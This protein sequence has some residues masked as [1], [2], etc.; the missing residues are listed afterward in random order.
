MA[1]KHTASLT[2]PLAYVGM[3]AMSVQSCGDACGPTALAR[4]LDVSYP[5]MCRRIMVLGGNYR[6]VAACVIHRVLE[7]YTVVRVHSYKR[8]RVF[9]SWR[10]GRRGGWVAVV[11][12]FGSR[13]HLVALRF[14]E[15]LDNGWVRGRAHIMALRVHAAWQVRSVTRVTRQR[16]AAVL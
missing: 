7:P 15:A 13:G 9:N 12:G 10:R 6:S 5:E 1:T 4:L 16:P 11:T 8:P 14:G 3:P 2:A